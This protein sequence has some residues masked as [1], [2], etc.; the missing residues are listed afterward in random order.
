MILL[1]EIEAYRETYFDAKSITS[2]PVELIS[3]P[4]DYYSF[5]WAAIK[6]LK[7]KNVVELGTYKGVSTRVML[8]AL[9]PNS[10]LV[11]VD[12]KEDAEYLN[13]VEDD[14]LKLIIG[15]SL[16]VADEFYDIDFLFVDT[17]H[18]YEVVCK[19]WDLYKTKLNSTAFV[20]FD[21]INLNEEMKKFWDE[22]EEEKYDVSQY[23]QSGFGVILY[24]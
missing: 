3:S 18:T 4:H 21:D 5:L 23:H 8:D 12:I 13:T 7:P 24:G 1:D 20:V 16:S 9:P 22:V 6:Y 19:E 11:T 10:K 14:R 15:N 17:D 2:V